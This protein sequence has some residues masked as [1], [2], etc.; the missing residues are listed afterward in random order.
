MDLDAKQAATFY[1]EMRTCL[2]EDPTKFFGAFDDKKF[3]GAKKLASFSGQLQS[4][5]DMNKP[6]A[7]KTKSDPNAAQK[8]RGSFLPQFRKC[9]DDTLTALEQ[10]PEKNQR[11]PQIENYRSAVSKLGDLSEQYYQEVQRSNKHSLLASGLLDQMAKA[12]LQ[13]DKYGFLEHNIDTL[14]DSA[15]KSQEALRAKCADGKPFKGGDDVRHVA[16]LNG[17]R[18]SIDHPDLMALYTSPIC[19][20]VCMK[21]TETSPEINYAA[22]YPHRPDFYQQQIF[23]PAGLNK[24]TKTFSENLDTVAKKWPEIKKQASYRARE[25]EKARQKEAAEKNRVKAR[26]KPT[27]SMNGAF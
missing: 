27:I 12:G 15:Q 5:S 25:H 8:L 2:K 10:M 13:P 20:A 16:V 14:C 26:S 11:L 23:D 3:P 4:F 9:C 19:T 18:Q 1:N 21:V 6:Y 24:M 17:I 7:P 22:N